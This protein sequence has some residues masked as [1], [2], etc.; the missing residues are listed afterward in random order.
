MLLVLYD[1]NPDIVFAWTQVLSDY[2][3]VIFGAGDLLR[4]RVDAVVSPANSFG[5]MD[6]GIDL[7]YRNFFGLGI[8]RRVQAVIGQRFGGEIPVGQAFIVPTDHKKIPRLVVAP[9][10]KTPQNIQGTDNVYRATRAALE[11]S[12]QAE[13][14]IERL[15]I[16]G[17]GTGIGKMDPFESAQQMLRAY[18]EVLKPKLRE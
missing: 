7:A 11:C 14:P 10:M 4:A 18:V 1:H 12:I 6:G 5:Y 16:P 15:G 3:G 8:Q 9:T 17:M 2:E 13:P